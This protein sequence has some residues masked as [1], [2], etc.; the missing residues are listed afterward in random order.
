MFLKGG[1]FVSFLMLTFS[2]Y[3]QTRGRGGKVSGDNY[4]VTFSNKIT[5]DKG[6]RPSRMIPRPE[7][8]VIVQSFGKG[9]MGVEIVQPNFSMTS[10]QYDIRKGMD[11]RDEKV[12]YFGGKAIWVSSSV[13][14]QERIYIQSLN[15]E[16]GSFEGDE[17][18]INATSDVVGG[19]HF[20]S[21]GP[22]GFSLSNLNRYSFSVSP[23]SSKLL[24]HYRKKPAKKSD[25]LNKAVHG[26]VVV[27]EN[28]NVL[29]RKEQ[30]MPR[31]EFMLK[32]LGAEVNNEGNVYFLAKVY[33]NE[34]RKYKKD[35]I[36]NYSLSVY[37]LTKDSKK[38]KEKSLKMTDGFMVASSFFVASTGEV[39]VCGTYSKKFKS[40]GACGIFYN[41]LDM[42]EKKS[43]NVTFVDFSSDIDANYEGPKH[44]KK[45]K[46]WEK[47][48]G[49]GFIPYLTFRDIFYNSKT[50]SM[51]MVMESY[52]IVVR[53]SN[54]GRTRTY[55][56]YDDVYAL[57]VDTEKQQIEQS[58]KIP[59]YQFGVDR[60]FDLGMS[61]F[62]DGNVLHVFFI[63]NKKNLE[64]TPD[65]VPARHV[66]G[67]G[68]F[69][70]GAT[71]DFGASSD[72][73]RFLIYDVKQE[74]KYCDPSGMIK[75]KDGYYG[76]G[77]DKAAVSNAFYL[78]K[79]SAK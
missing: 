19:V 26:F 76:I 2:L 33:S 45:I 48:Y 34:V 7:G 55:Y 51:V 64:I 75:A 58:H 54:N 16:N 12:V 79:V 18:E 53:T 73:N 70:T 62:M 20:Q 44:Y 25:K 43:G 67:L 17:T 47:K 49:T 63:D 9:K 29:W 22:F 60:N 71:V 65:M 32:F 5:L 13:D 38:A 42:S 56:Y 11:R 66:T 27:D 77:Y 41:I 40:P 59:K 36:P 37:E 10:K 1:L 8:G 6:T 4:D 30:E 69:L 35:D 21:F 28:F 52:H 57:L 23:D 3:A 68:G 15:E 72:V 31:T 78:Y 39:V 50:K 24:V 14:S 46:K 61:S 74:R